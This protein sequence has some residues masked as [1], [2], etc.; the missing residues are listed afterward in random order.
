MFLFKE[1]ERE[2]V[3]VRLQKSTNKSRKKKKRA[4]KTVKENREGNY[5]ICFLKKNL[6]A[7]QCTNMKFGVDIFASQKGVILF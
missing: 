2:R 3:C 7:R 5:T 1:R 4:L 6:K